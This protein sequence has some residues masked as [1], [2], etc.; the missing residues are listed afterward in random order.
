M[1]TKP[2]TKTTLSILLV[3][4]L[5]LTWQAMPVL[6]DDPPY[7]R[8]TTG[9]VY[10]TTGVENPL[11]IFLTNTGDS[12]VYEVTTIL[13]V[14]AGTPGISVVSLAHNLV[15]KI[16]ENKVHTLTPS[17]YVSENTP[18][19]SYTLQ[20]QLSYRMYSGFGNPM[21]MTLPI[22]VVVN[23]VS[24]P[25]ALLV[26]RIPD[27]SLTAGVTQSLSYELLNL[28]EG[29]IT[30]LTST[31]SST[32]A[33]ISILEGQQAND[34]SVAVD[35]EFTHGFTAQVSKNAPMAPQVINAVVYYKDS[36]GRIQSEVFAL[37]YNVDSKSSDK[38]S[39]DVSLV[40]PRLVGGT[41]NNVSVSLVN[42]GESVSDLDV[43]L[44]SNSPYIVVLENSRY[45]QDALAEDST[46][47]YD[48]VL[49]V[50][51]NTPVGVYTMTASAS[52][53]DGDGVDRM[54]SYTLGVS[55]ESISVSTQ[56]TVVLRSYNT[57]KEKINPGDFFDIYFDIECLGT[58]A[59]DVQ[60]VLTLDAQTGFS[61][62][63]PTL[64]HVGEI[65]PGEEKTASYNLLI[66][67]Q[68][69]AGQ[70]PIRVTVNYMD[71]EGMPRSLVETITLDVRG[72]INFRLLDSQPVEIIKGAASEIET[73]LLL[74]GTESVDFVSIELME[75]EH[76][77]A[78]SG[79]YEYI[80]AVDPDSPIPFDLRI[81]VKDTT[82]EGEYTI[83]M[84]VLYTDDLNQEYETMLEIPVNVIIDTNDDAQ[85]N[86]GGFWGWLRSLFGWS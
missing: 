21:S 77:D 24:E 69:R 70:Y 82:G 29:E 12:D 56:T 16:N 51:R 83:K 36:T 25:E 14:P 31:L 40:D 84:K 78:V 60:V 42:L 81:D 76:F 4:A 26:A 80:G 33:Y 85:A 5:S 57:S 7:L 65:M 37:T 38:V 10:M 75:D 30:D 15:H 17:I 43:K 62:M 46:S 20:L 86:T 35:G 22:A 9:D 34:T 59:Q 64:V 52:Y 50:S 72:I 68:T 6:A 2:R 32:S 8:V 1:V 49:A 61:A 3:L 39:V 58:T 66:S 13:T 67:G 53:K 18:F 73:D 11:D 63:S 55:V 79:S 74:L 54:E 47:L 71:S 48:A 23:S 19:G 28:G 41:E 44:V 27:R 45:T